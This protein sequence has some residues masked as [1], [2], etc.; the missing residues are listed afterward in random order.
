MIEYSTG[1]QGGETHIPSIEV[2]FDRKWFGYDSTKANEG[3]RWGRFYATG[4]LVITLDRRNIKGYQNSREDARPYPKFDDFFPDIDSW[5]K[6]GTWERN[7][8]Y[9]KYYYFPNGETGY[10]S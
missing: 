1:I 5:K 9:E 10:R 4:A 7:R 3:P 8:A 2:H 6:P